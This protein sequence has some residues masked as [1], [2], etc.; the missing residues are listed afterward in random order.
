M[1]R[2]PPR[3]TRTD[4]LVPSTPLVRSFVALEAEQNRRLVREVL[5]ERSNAHARPLRNAGSGEPSGSFCPQNLNSGVEDGCDEVVC[6]RLFWLL[7][8]GNLR[9]WALCHGLL[10][11]CE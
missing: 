9:A 10:R 7:S 1:R 4:T 11:G 3:S 8:R 5:V 2:R 6:A